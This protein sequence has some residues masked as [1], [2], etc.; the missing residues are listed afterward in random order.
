MKTKVSE[1]M[2]ATKM[3]IVAA[4]RDNPNITIN[5]LMILIGLSEPGIKKNLKQLKDNGI[6][7]RVG[8][9]KTGYWEVRNDYKFV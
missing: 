7:T 1:K 2:N 6:I 9:N 8:A 5:Q 4:M 3:K